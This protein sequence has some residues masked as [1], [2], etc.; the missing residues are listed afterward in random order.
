[1]D[2]IE[3]FEGPYSFLSNFHPCHIIYEGI[4][5]NTVENAFQA[6]KST[7]KRKMSDFVALTPGIA[8]QLGR[9]I[10]LRPDWE[11]VK[12]GIM[13]NLVK[14]KFLLPENE[15]LRHKLLETGNTELVEGNWWHDY[16]WGVD[17]TTGKGRNKLG[18]IL[19]QVRE[20][21]KNPPANKYVIVKIEKNAEK[22]ITTVLDELITRDILPVLTELRSVA[23]DMANSGKHG[24][25]PYDETFNETVE[26]G[27]YLNGNGWTAK[28]GTNIRIINCGLA[29]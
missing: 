1:M 15:R 12:D 29:E 24:E 25:Y 5:F 7:D 20:L 19:M 9:Q 22:E 21:A 4:T 6:A 23:F 17:A 10:S 27:F 2:K 28:D 3:R 16:Y 11:T 13:L 8:K 18:R 14:Q 26:A